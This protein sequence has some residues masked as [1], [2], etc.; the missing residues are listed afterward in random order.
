MFT[1]FNNNKYP[2]IC[3]LDRTHVKKQH[4]TDY[5]TLLKCSLVI[6]LDHDATFYR[7]PSN[8]Q[9]HWYYLL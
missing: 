7:Q 6:M 8:Q 1:T 3:T 2:K 5:G 9:R 4:N